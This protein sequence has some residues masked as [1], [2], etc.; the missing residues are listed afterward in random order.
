MCRDST[1]YPNPPL[2]LRISDGPY[3]DR[4]TVAWDL[5]STDSVGISTKRPLSGFI[6]EAKQA[7]EE[8]FED[9]GHFNSSVT[10]ASLV[11][12][13]PGTTY[14]VRVLSTN[15]AGRTPSNVLTIITPTA[16]DSVHS[17]QSTTTVLNCVLT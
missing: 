8:S 15:Q 1:D 2:N 6:V 9:F 12:L 17:N 4:A 14:L 13:H 3:P 11:S 5:P 7:E 16:G 10:S